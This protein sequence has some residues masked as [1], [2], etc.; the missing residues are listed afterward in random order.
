VKPTAGNHLKTK[1]LET[2]S[3]TEAQTE[4]EWK[5]KTERI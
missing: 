5:G 4:A 3:A 1:K 2:F